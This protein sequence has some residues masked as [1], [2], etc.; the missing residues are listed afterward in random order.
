MERSIKEYYLMIVGGTV[1]MLSG[2]FVNPIFAPFVRNEFT[3]S[4]QL[5]GLAVSGYFFLR[6]LSEFP[7][8]VL[9]DRIEPRIPL[10]AGRGLAVLGAFVCYRT[11]S[12]WLLILARLLWG[13]GDASFFCI[14]MSYVSR[15]FASERRG[16]AM[17][18]FQ[19][20]EMVGNLVGQTL[21]GV[22]AASYGL[23]INFLV[24]TGLGV[25]ALLIVTMIKGMEDEAGTGK[26]VPSLMP[27]RQE[28]VTVLNVTV[29]GA[30]IINLGCMIINTGLLGTILP[31]Y[32]TEELSLPLNIYALLVAGST[33]GSV[34][35]NLLGGFLSDRIGRRKILAVGLV[36]GV[37]SLLG[38]TMFKGFYQLLGVMFM[39]GIFWGVIYGVIPAFIADAVPDMVRGKAIGTFRTFMDMGGLLGPMIMSTFVEVVG[40]PMGYIQSFYLGIGITAACLVLVLRL[41]EPGST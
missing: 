2:G 5:V 23:R 26:P 8:G 21:G 33:V 36:V 39:R 28:M 16:R 37:V 9:S 10:M 15:L 18:F 34:A 3:A 20:V 41:R 35:G 7:I 19:A 4:L 6:M 12:I 11:E 29:I 27:T 1:T 17:G 30:C 14:G 22:V 32:A 13:M 25:T 38:L 24:C 31:I 40:P